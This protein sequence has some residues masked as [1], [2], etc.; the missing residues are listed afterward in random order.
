MKDC[1]YQYRKGLYEALNGNVSY[2]GSDVPV[3]EFA[4]D[5]QATPYIQILNMNSTSEDDDDRFSQLV[6]T[7]IQVVTSH[8]GDPGNFGSKKSDDIMNDIMELLITK[9]VTA[10]DR[11]VHI[12]M[13]DFE[14]AG[15]YFVSLN[16]GNYYDGNKLLVIKILTITTMIDEV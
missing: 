15:C 6:T 8:E 2:D 10:S 1:F 16:Y 3:M 4:G 9:G 7:D 12:D 11:A 5:N 14:D 13:D